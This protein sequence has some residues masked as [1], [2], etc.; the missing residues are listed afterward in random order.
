MKK[1]E[2]F[3]T[4]VGIDVSKEKLDIYYSWNGKN[5]QI[6]NNKSA[7][8]SFIKYF[9]QE[10]EKLLVVIDL[11]GGYE[12]TAVRHFCKAG[13]NVHRA[14]G[15]KV[16]NFIR[17]YGQNAKTDKI[18]AFMLTEYAKTFQ[19]RLKLYKY[20]EKEEQERNLANIIR[21]LFDIE[22]ILQKEKNRF[23]APDNQAIKKS[24]EKMIKI[25]N[26]QK[27]TLEQQIQQEIDKDEQIKAKQQVIMAQKGI[28]QKTS[29]IL[30]A[31]LPELGRLNRREIAALSG[32][33]PYSNDSGTIHARRK[34][35]TGRK[36]VK[37][38]LFI[39][40]LV[41]IK[42]DKKIKAF[43]EKLISKAKAKMVAIIACMRKLITLLNARCKAFYNNI[44]F[45]EY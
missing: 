16:K 26:K 37:R 17:A 15:R 19:N 42:Y 35:R 28:G 13:F 32:T 5:E 20:N 2:K 8:R 34:T 21:R 18:D 6:K 43:Y 36:Q 3:K 44:A 25:L 7:I 39:C 31:L 24:I 33:A 11:T 4:F 9:K 14:E 23:K 41:A 22:E 45:V 27:E 12:A 1:E 10:K 38:T 30:L 40:A 29:M